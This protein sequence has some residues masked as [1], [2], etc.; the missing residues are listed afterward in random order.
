[1]PAP[2]PFTEPDARHEWL[3]DQLRR[4]RVLPDGERI[5]F[6]TISRSGTRLSHAL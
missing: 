6:A 2:D 1:M 5:S 3:R 4:K